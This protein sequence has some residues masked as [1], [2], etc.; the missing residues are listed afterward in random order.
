MD[1][2]ERRI[3]NRDRGGTTRFGVTLCN[4]QARQSHNR[5]SRKGFLADWKS[6]LLWFA[7]A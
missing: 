1:D 3:E 6:S 2:R 7:A 4:Q 5:K